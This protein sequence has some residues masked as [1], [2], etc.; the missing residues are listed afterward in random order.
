MRQLTLALLVLAV[1]AC[2]DGGGSEQDVAGDTGAD[3][4]Q[5]LAVDQA[6]DTAS[7]TDASSVRGIEAC[8]DDECST[9]LEIL[10]ERTDDFRG[11]QAV[12]SLRAVGASV[13]ET[14]GLVATEEPELSWSL[15][16]P[17]GSSSPWAVT[18]D[19]TVFSAQ[20]IETQD[21]DVP[22]ARYEF[23]LWPPT[24]SD[25]PAA[26]VTVRALWPVP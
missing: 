17:G 14:V 7:D 5:D 11:T 1:T 19:G 22:V 9:D 15:G 24:N 18:P 13:E 23:R 4:A 3:L 12:F 20:Y 6:E 21:V 2:D 16:T 8:Y 25:T 26:V 10:L